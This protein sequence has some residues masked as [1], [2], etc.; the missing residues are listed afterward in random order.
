MELRNLVE[1]G[2]TGV[3]HLH[4]LNPVMAD[5][6]NQQQA[7]KFGEEF[8]ASLTNS[9]A[10]VGGSSGPSTT[11]CRT[12]PATTARRRA[13]ANVVER[14]DLVHVLAARTPS[15]SR[16]GSGP[17]EKV[18]ASSTPATSVRTRTGCRESRPATSWG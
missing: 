9:S 3:L 8:C 6:A 2:I 5:A 4:W 18:L 13:W 1:R 16:R 15:W 12:A 17:P 10:L 11:S 7:R 14:A